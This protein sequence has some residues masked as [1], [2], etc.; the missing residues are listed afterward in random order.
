MKQILLSILFF[1]T[2]TAAIAMSPSERRDKIMEAA[3]DSVIQVPALCFKDVN[4]Q[5]KVLNFDNFRVIAKEEFDG[6]KNKRFLV[7]GINTHIILGFI[8]REDNIHCLELVMENKYISS[9]P[10]Q[11]G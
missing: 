7:Y 1:L 8:V 2:T 9:K 5:K 6:G 10:P 4:F 3:P 11:R